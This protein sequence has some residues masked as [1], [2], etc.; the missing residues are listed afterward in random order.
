M[1]LSITTTHQPATALGYLLAKHPDRC[2]RFSLNFG[3]ARVWYPQADEDCCEAVLYV[4]VDPVQLVRGRGEGEGAL[5]Q[6]V[7]DRPYTASSFMSVALAQ[8]LASALRGDCKTHPE[9]AQTALPLSAEIPVLRAR[10]G[11]EVIRRCFEP[12][13]YTVDCEVLPLDPSFPEWGDSDYVR[14]RL[15]GQ[16]R[17]SALLRHLYILLPAIDGDRHHYVG[18]DE[19]DKLVAKA[20]EWLPS[21]P[22]RDWIVG[23]YLKR[24]RS[25]VR[26]ALAKLTEA[27]E[28]ELDETEASREVPEQL[29]EKPLSLN[30]QRMQTIAGLLRE[31]GARS[32]VDLGCGEGRLLARLLDER[33]YE[34]LLGVDVSMIALERAADRLKLD[35]L[36]PMVR[37][38]VALLQGSLT[39][40]DARLSG[41]DAACAVE[42]VEHLEPER[43]SA[44][45]AAVF[46]FARPGHIL[47]TSP[48]A[49][50][51]VRFETLPAGRYRHPDHRF[52]WTRAEFH[53]WA[54]GVCARHG[55]QWT[56][57]PI[58]PVDPEVGPP[59]QLAVF[60]R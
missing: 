37:A 12:L 46:E 39:Y 13:G 41:F 8:V 47:I 40:R 56:W 53:A 45:E 6:Y 33:H 11:V 26:A 58:G 60:S 31:S 34:R 18:D 44:F 23:R 59:T 54:E 3:E 22:E 1:L 4:D 19:V 28:T 9:L 50:Y 51:N 38:R 16:L 7:N 55:Y 17:L 20:G 43:L 32:V 24:R 35:R 25:L 42:V 21:H 27:D 49:E 15:S 5:S 36:P 52:E 2:Q 14:L 48:N 57:H 10:G 29:L 30:E